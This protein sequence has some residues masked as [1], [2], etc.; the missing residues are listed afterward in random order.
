MRFLIS[1]VFMGMLALSSQAFAETYY[2]EDA[3]R[4]L[5]EGKVVASK[6]TETGGHYTRVRYK[7]VYYACYTDLEWSKHFIVM[8]CADFKPPA[9]Q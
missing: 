8:K 2:G 1:M 9:N 6:W 5:V 4:I 7:N 3:N